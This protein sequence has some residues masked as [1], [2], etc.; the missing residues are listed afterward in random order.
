MPARNFEYLVF[1]SKNHKV[2]KK[3]LYE[4]YGKASEKS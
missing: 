3:T 2:K 4:D 1:S